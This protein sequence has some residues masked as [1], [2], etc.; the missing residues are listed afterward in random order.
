VISA[1]SLIACSL[2]SGLFS[3]PRSLC[4]RALCCRNFHRTLSD[5]VL[6]FAGVF[7]A[8]SLSAGPVLLELFTVCF[9]SAGFV[10]LDII[11][12][13]SMSAGSELPE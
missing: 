13:F 10:K 8:L 5:R 9:P 6:C 2:L 3:A 7:T 12:S 1:L 11:A 4:A